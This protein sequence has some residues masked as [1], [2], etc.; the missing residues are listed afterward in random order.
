[1]SWES[2]LFATILDVLVVALAILALIFYLRHRHAV[3]SQG[4]T[5]GFVIILVG[6]GAISTYYFSDLLIRFVPPFQ[7]T[8]TAA[9]QHDPH[10]DWAWYFVLVGNIAVYLGLLVLF[11]TLIPK[12]SRY[13]SELEQLKNEFCNKNTELES[14]VSERTRALTESNQKLRK[15][16]D[17]HNVSKIALLQSEK[18]FR[19]LFDESPTIFLTLTPDQVISDISL[20]G[21]RVLGLSTVE[22]VGKDFSSLLFPEE[23]TQHCQFIDRCFIESSRNATTQMRFQLQSGETIWVKVTASVIQETGADEYLLMVCQDISES[24]KLA[25]TLKFQASHDDLTKLYNRRALEQYLNDIFERQS[26]FSKPAAFFYIDVDQL[27]VVNDTCGHIAGDELLKQLVTV[28]TDASK[29]HD[30]FARIGADEFAI[31]KENTSKEEALGIAETIRNAAEDL[32]FIWGSQSFRQSVSIGIA[33]TSPRICTLTDIFGAADAACYL[34]K[35]AGRNRVVLHKESR[36]AVEDS[37]HDMHWVSRL[38]RA[39]EEDRF[40]LFF[41]PIVNLRNPYDDYIHYE[42]LLRGI[43][44]EGRHI[45]PDIFLPAAERF[46]ISNQIDLWVVSSTLE[47]LRKS[48]RHTRKLQCCSINLSSNSLANDQTRSAIK[49]LVIRAGIPINKIC[50]EITETSAIRNLTEATEFIEDLKALGCRFAL[51]DFGTGFSSLGYL[52]A[53]AVDYLK[54][55]GSFVKDIVEDRIDRAMVTA[56]SSI[57]RA[58]DITTIAEYVENEQTLKTLISIDVDLGQGIGLAKPMPL[59]S[60]HKFYRTDEPVSPSPERDFPK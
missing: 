19:T 3:S 26:L 30:M 49:Q 21:A 37:R 54:I 8:R 11:T 31:I 24:K 36:E 58:M 33:L 7:Q 28:I 48:P 34:A 53:L 25:E 16:V 5:G 44:S 12:S 17:D 38:Q 27:K 46:G 52:K 20:Y 47:F 55:D 50:F 39:L 51:D 59:S 4:Y 29:S 35:E 40:E 10:L 6:M 1:M 15:V 42:M 18:K 23:K 13:L 41:Q 60:I 56:I 43:D 32:T 45:Q 22:I 14:M 57:G 2:E 9:M